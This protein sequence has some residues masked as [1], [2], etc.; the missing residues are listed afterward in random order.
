METPELDYCSRCGVS[1][2]PEYLKEKSG[3]LLCPECFNEPM[4]FDEFDRFCG[5][6]DLYEEMKNLNTNG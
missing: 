5:W 1:I 2:P 6:F 4:P 3:L